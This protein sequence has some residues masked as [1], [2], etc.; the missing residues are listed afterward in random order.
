MMH[1][2]AENLDFENASQLRNKIAMLSQGVSGAQLLA[3]LGIYSAAGNEPE[4]NP[5]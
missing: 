1:E 2:A 3:L 5:L 4:M